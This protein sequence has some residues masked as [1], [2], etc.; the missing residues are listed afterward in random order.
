MQDAPLVQVLESG[1]D[2]AQVVAHLWLQQGVPGLPDVGQ[3]LQRATASAPGPPSLTLP[4]TVLA[5]GRDRAPALGLKAP[6]SLPLPLSSL[7]FRLQS[8]RKMYMLSA[9]SKWCEKRT[10]WRCCRPRCSS[11]SFRICNGGAGWSSFKG[12]LTTVP[13]PPLIRW[14]WGPPSRVDAAW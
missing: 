8:S 1:K 11:I 3:G 9:S 10:M 4:P 13:T 12:S 14:A 7:T 5:E 6:F 2:L